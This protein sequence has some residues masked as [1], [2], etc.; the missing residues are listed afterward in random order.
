[1]ANL[2]RRACPFS[3]LVVLLPLTSAAQSTGAIAGT[4]RDA[5]GAVLPGVTVEA[6]SPALIE[7]ARSASTDER[8]QYRIIDLR[9]GTYTTTFTLSGFS[10]V[11]REAIE[12]WAG[13]PAAVNAELRVGSIEEPVTVTA[14]SPI[15]DVQNVAQQRVMNREV[16]D[17]IPT[18]KLFSN[19]AVLVPGMTVR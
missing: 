3:C 15:V 16:I 1:M 14:A 10:T 17:A 6:S 19:L 7:G 8:G 9:P 18:G 5:T 2:K 13:F 4:V 12:F 11:R